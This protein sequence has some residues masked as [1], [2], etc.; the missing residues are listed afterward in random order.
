MTNQPGDLWASSR[1][2]LAMQAAHLALEVLVFLYPAARVAHTLP[3]IAARGHSLSSRLLSP[4][5]TPSPTDP[6]AE[7]VGTIC[8]EEV[9]FSLPGYYFSPHCFYLNTKHRLPYAI[10]VSL[11]ASLSRCF[12]GLVWTAVHLAHGNAPSQ[13]EWLSDLDMSEC[14]SE[15]N[16]G[17]NG[18]K[19]RID[20]SI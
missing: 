17:I 19:L 11:S 12:T 5:L 2:F 4:P 1:L 14:F 13:E 16:E 20:V 9:T 10:L 15:L 6:L 3:W 8:A 18:L 7:S